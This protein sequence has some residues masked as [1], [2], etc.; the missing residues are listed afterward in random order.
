[1]LH[2]AGSFAVHTCANAGYPQGSVV[3][4]MR[5]WAL[6]MRNLL[7]DRSFVFA[8]VHCS[9]GLIPAIY[10][11]LRSPSHHVPLLWFSSP[12][13]AFGTLAFSRFQLIRYSTVLLSLSSWS[14]LLCII[15]SSSP[16]ETHKRYKKRSATFSHDSSCSTHPPCFSPFK[17][18]DHTFLIP[19]RLRPSHI[20]FSGDSSSAFLCSRGA[21]WLS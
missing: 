18:P 12:S 16:T 2:R 17:G 15:E 8:A 6:L 10:S 13:P 3:S 5:S 14:W 20:R 4:S 21:R 1:M 19:Q 9:F 11:A 7:G